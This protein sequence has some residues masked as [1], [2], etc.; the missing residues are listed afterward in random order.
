MPIGHWGGVHRTGEQAVQL[1]QKTAPVWMSGNGLL[2][3]LDL[4][5][6]ECA[7]MDHC[8]VDLIMSASNTPRGLGAFGD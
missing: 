7:V 5:G 6:T 4:H 2:A 1:E 8:I 3:K